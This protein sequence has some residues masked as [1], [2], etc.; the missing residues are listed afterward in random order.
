MHRL[1]PLFCFSLALI[2]AHAAERPNILFIFSDDQSYKTVSCYP[3]ALPGV[4]TPAIDALAK[5]GVR[6]THAYMGAWCM[7]SR[8]TLLT[9]RH[10]HGIESMRMTGKY[11]AS[12]YNPDQCPFW[13][14]VFRA[15]GYHTAHIGK[16]HTGTDGGFGRD[17]DYQIIWNRPKYP[18][19]AGAYYDDQILEFNGVQKRTS[20][21]STDNYTQWACD[22]IRGEHRPAGKPWYLWLCYGA[23]HGPTIPAERH[24]GSHKD[25]AVKVP[26]DIL[27]PRPGKPDYLNA[28]QS[29]IR[30]KKGEIVAKKSE[31][32]FGDETG[33]KSRSYGD[34]I[35]QVNDC[36]AALDEGVAR[37]M[38]ALKDSGQLANTLVVFKSIACYS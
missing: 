25:D 15:G 13:P 28:T 32:A 30:D 11:P 10:P 18:D 6:F 23:I 2:R 27:P 26:A 29:W 3:E 31:E 5:S 17:W 7:P 38:Q 4:R 37:V 21:Y 34:Y 35:H 14:A 24:R 19:N 20:G 12:E 22:Y 9:G 36:V 1:L 16:W 8:A 33:K